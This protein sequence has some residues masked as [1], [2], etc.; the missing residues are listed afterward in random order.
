LKKNCKKILWHKD[1]WEGGKLSPGSD[2]PRFHLQMF[3][4]TACHQPATKDTQP[5]VQD[6]AGQWGS[7]LPSCY[8]SFF[9]HGAWGRHPSYLPLATAQRLARLQQ[10]RLKRCLPCLLDDKFTARKIVS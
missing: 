6:S 9:F 2:A 4:A 7:G 10:Q 1:F 8:L 3:T 5:L